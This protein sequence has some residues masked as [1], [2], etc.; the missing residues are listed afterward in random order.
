M[1][2]RQDEPQPIVLLVAR[3]LERQISKL[4]IVPFVALDPVERAPRGDG[5]QPRARSVRNA[6]TRPAFHG[7]NQ[8][9]LGALL[10]QIKIAETADEC[11]RD[12][13]RFLAEDLGEGRRSRCGGASHSCYRCSITGLISSVPR[14]GQLLA[15]ASA[16][17]RLATS[18]SVYPPTISLPSRNRPSFTSGL[19]SAWKR[20]VVAVSGPCNWLPWPS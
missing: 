12:P 4:A 3:R 19:P 7:R 16:S 18:T 1:A 10:R 8:R 9:V 14:P 2:T 17:S 6:V 20:I 5:Q 15:M 13:A 11:G